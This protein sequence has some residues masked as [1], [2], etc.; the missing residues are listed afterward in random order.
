MDSTPTKVNPRYLLPGTV[1]GFYSIVDLIG[2][3]AMGAT[4]RAT[5]A[6]KV[7]AL[8]I[9]TFQL[10]ELTAEQRRS[11]EARIRREVAALN[12]LDHPNIVAIRAHDVWPE[13]E[14]GYPYLVMDYV[15]GPPLLTW[16]VQKQPS[17]TVILR[18]FRTIGTALAEM[19]RLRIFHRDL[20][21]ANILV[22]LVDDEPVV[23]DFGIARPLST[24]TVTQH[25]SMVGTVPFWS[26]EYCAY[27]GSEAMENLQPFVN[28]PQTDLW[29]LGVL[30][31]EALTGV[32]P[33]TT[34][35]EESPGRLIDIILN[36][37]I[38]PPSSHNPAVPPAVDELL[39]KLLAKKPE[40]RTPSGMALAEAVDECLATSST[41]E[42]LQPFPVPMRPGKGGAPTPRLT[43]PSVQALAAAS[44]P[45][46]EVVR[47][48]AILAVLPSASA[49]PVP[50]SAGIP[51]GPAA[52][53]PAPSTSAAPPS[54]PT[55][56][57]SAF[58]PPSSHQ[59]RYTPPAGAAPAAAAPAGQL[60][61]AIHEVQEALRRPAP[62]PPPSSRTWLVAGG[63]AAA[64]ALVVGLV[65]RA[66]G[67]PQDAPR[68]LLT[69]YSDGG[70]PS[71][72][73]EGLVA[74]MPPP[75][76]REATP[77]PQV[78]APAAPATGASVSVPPPTE[79]TRAVRAPRGGEA[80]RI[81]EAL[82]REY[83]RPRV[84][85]DGALTAGAGET[86]A[87]APAEVA[88]APAAPP[89]PS[90]L[91]V[92]SSGAADAGSAK[93]A[94]LGVPMGA[95]IKARLKNNVDS[96]AC[97]NGPVEAELVRAHVERGAVVLPSRTRLYG[98]CSTSAGRFLISFTNVRLPSFATYEFQG[99][100]LDTAE[101][102]A[103]LRAT[104][105]VAA[106]A[107][108]TDVGAEVAKGAAST[109]LSTVTGGTAADVVRGAGGA[110]LQQG[111]GGTST[112]QDVLFLD[113]GKDF[114][115]IVK[116]AF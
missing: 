29:A 93:V 116:A 99:L 65:M 97:A 39:A 89:T 46:E 67:T 21:S 78:P 7:Y 91:Q 72:S 100:A 4:Y 80:G 17:L 98:T 58:V 14:Y 24:R 5:R 107:P 18:V 112:P 25:Y 56:Q 113:A 62:P 33:F 95:H 84:T 77:T 74:E 68:T 19:H 26:P 20:K 45:S 109:V 81:N 102:K 69:A 94:E 27:A 55:P 6:G 32:F 8:K 40:E 103:G 47:D 57:T 50:S 42:W 31:Y 75:Q 110:I 49:L 59:L 70:T 23:I 115:V 63:A 11:E 48:S 30:F 87:Q 22:R 64:A 3:G 9:A 92:S 34:E 41:A 111:G 43:S 76:V 86:A 37:P 10:E 60:A 71:L 83:G 36:Q 66:P 38:A 15:D 79:G 44:P 114:E 61:T 90:W 2:T 96:D 13:P 54:A 101:Q 73:S 28:T 104:R 105:S 1:V 52:A 16:R 82:T 12:G 35:K 106:A 53:A 85:P 88:R 108:R 51:V